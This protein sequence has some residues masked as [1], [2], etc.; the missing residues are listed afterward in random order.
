M[1]AI[2]PPL[3]ALHGA[4]LEHSS[5]VAHGFINTAEHLTASTLR[6]HNRL[7]ESLVRRSRAQAWSPLLVADAASDPAVVELG[8]AIVQE[9]IHLSADLGTRWIALGE[10][11]QHGYNAVVDNWLSH[12]RKL[13]HSL[14]VGTGIAVL[15]KAVESADRSVSEAAEVAVGATEALADEAERIEEAIQPRKR[16]RKG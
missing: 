8:A 4:R 10:W 11:H 3:A 5:A 13:F 6:L 15:Q 12:W 9:Q 2:N 1:L 16:A 14:P 7:L